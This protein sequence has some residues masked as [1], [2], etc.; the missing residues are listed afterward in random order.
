LFIFEFFV[1]LL[2]LQKKK[3]KKKKDEPIPFIILIFLQLLSG[4]ES[5]MVEEFAEE[6]ADEELDD[7]EQDE[8]EDHFSIPGASKE[9]RD[10]EEEPNSPDYWIYFAKPEERKV[11]KPEEHGL[12]LY[13]SQKLGASIAEFYRS[14]ETTTFTVGVF[15]GTVQG[16]GFPIDFLNFIHA[17]ARPK[18]LI[19]CGICAG[20]GDIKPGDVC[21]GERS[22]VLQGKAVGMNITDLKLE[23]VLPASATLTGG[24][25]SYWSTLESREG[26][27]IHCG[28]YIQSPFVMAYDLN[29]LNGL[30]QP[31]DRKLIALDMESWFYFT[32]QDHLKVEMIL[33][34]VKGVSDTGAKK[35]DEFHSKAVNNSVN[36]AVNILKNVAHQ[37]S[38]PEF[39]AQGRSLSNSHVVSKRRKNTPNKLSIQVSH[40]QAQAALSKEL[41]GNELASALETLDNSLR[42]F[43][44]L[45]ITKLKKNHQHFSKQA[46]IIL[47][48]LIGR[49]VSEVTE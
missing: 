16:A 8:E 45:G 40:Q 21:I 32:V 15:N 41:N 9:K 17:R 4:M 18:A 10:R 24:S 38:L 7:E 49:D 23:T 44:K 26:F 13:A 20:L 43:G 2:T 36:V 39:K 34:V 47:A 12:A 5:A 28:S 11:F 30:F 19:M 37:Q 14:K 22:V 35:T 25:T 3:K 46:L 6:F 31:G 42:T 33:P 48:R 27:Q 1:F 29:F